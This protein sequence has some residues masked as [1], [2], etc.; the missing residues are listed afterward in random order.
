MITTI[1]IIITT[2][3]I[4]TILIISYT[5]WSTGHIEFRL[6]CNSSINIMLSNVNKVIVCSD[7]L[8]IRIARMS[9]KFNAIQCN[10][11]QF[12]A[13][14]YNSMQFNAIRCNSMQFDTIQYKLSTLRWLF[15]SATSRLLLILQAC[16]LHSRD[17]PKEYII[18]IFLN[19]N[20]YSRSGPRIRRAS[21]T[22]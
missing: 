17:P 18:T 16:P 2:M 6:L 20:P 11:M 8:H 12:D 3:I 15:W 21:C 1:M 19:D 7:K 10:S 5:R 22:C 9:K 4:T 14:R 13:I